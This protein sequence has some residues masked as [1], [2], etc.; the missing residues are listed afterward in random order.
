V[1]HEPA[2]TGTKT[3]SRCKATLHVLAFSISHST[4][5][6]L[7]PLCRPC[8]YKATHDTPSATRR[9]NHTYEKHRIGMFP[10]KYEP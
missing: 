2:C 9:R 5:D 6:G 8:Q 7:Q 3:C 1:R 10:T 4:L